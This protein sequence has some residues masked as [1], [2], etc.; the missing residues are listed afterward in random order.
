MLIMP[1]CSYGAALED[2]SRQLRTCQRHE[3]DDGGWLRHVV[4]QYSTDYR[5][6]LVLVMTD[7]LDPQLRRHWGRPSRRISYLPL[8]DLLMNKMKPIDEPAEAVDLLVLLTCE[9]SLDF[10][11]FCERE[12]S[13]LRNEVS[14]NDDVDSM[15]ATADACW[16]LHRAVVAVKAAQGPHPPPSLA[17]VQ[18]PNFPEWC[19]Q[20]TRPGGDALRPTQCAADALVQ[21]RDAL[22]RDVFAALLAT[23]SHRPRLGRWRRG[24]IPGPTSAVDMDSSQPSGYPGM[25]L[26]WIARHDTVRAALDQG[27]TA[28][29]LY[30]LGLVC[31]VESVG[32]RRDLTVKPGLDGLKAQHACSSF[33]VFRMCHEA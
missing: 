9:A 15:R 19:R 27:V 8:P 5:A 31:C 28:G 3:G 10:I 26:V 25:G 12:V 32:N 4:L 23:T 18:W 11:G 21:A 13:R 29:G 1:G 20:D 30:G 16:Y 22:K 6:L 2:L 24:H 7:T 17:C 14:A 33:M